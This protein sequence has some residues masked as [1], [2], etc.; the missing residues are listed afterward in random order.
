MKGRCVRRTERQSKRISCVSSS[1]PWHY[2]SILFLFWL[3]LY[4]PHFTIQCFRGSIKRLPSIC[5]VHCCCCNIVTGEEAPLGWTLQY[6]P[7][8]KQCYVIREKQRWTEKQ[9]RWGGR[10]GRGE[11]FKRTKSSIRTSGRRLCRLTDGSGKHKV[12]FMIWLDWADSSAP[13]ISHLISLLL[14]KP[15]LQT[16]TQTIPHSHLRLAIQA[17]S[18]TN[19]V[20]QLQTT[21]AFN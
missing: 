15:K 19:G 5:H 20:K 17:K 4:L 9:R 21:S 12:C 6:L 13:L 18:W 16:Q 8:N 1:P 11:I 7:F 3:Q 14:C 10:S 2:L